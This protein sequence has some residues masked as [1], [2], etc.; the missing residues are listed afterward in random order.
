MDN[1]L[2]FAFWLGKALGRFGYEA[3]PARNVADALGLLSQIPLSPRL[4]IFGEMP[5]EC[6]TLI[7]GC[8]RREPE[9]RILRLTEDTPAVV[10]S[11]ESYNEQHKP[12]RRQDDELAGLLLAI[13]N[14]AAEPVMP[15]DSFSR[16]VSRAL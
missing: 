4:L 7:D 5:S 6:Q 16:Y 9:L 11:G 14:M 8:R 12:A 13:E 1:D 3:F 2:G 10:R 15:V